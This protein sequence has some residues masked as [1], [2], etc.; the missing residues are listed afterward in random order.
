MIQKEK[1]AFGGLLLNDII[2]K[3]DEAT[4]RQFYIDGGALILTSSGQ[5]LFGSANKDEV[6]GSLK[7]YQNDS[8]QRQQQGV[9]RIYLANGGNGE[10]YSVGGHDLVIKESRSNQS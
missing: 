7:D 3:P 6:I 4:W 9:G 1:G 10:V 5:Q 8:L 2:T